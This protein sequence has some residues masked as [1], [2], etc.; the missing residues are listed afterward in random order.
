MPEILSDDG[1][2][3]GCFL[4]SLNLLS[5]PTLRAFRR[6]E[7]YGLP[8]L[9]AAK[10]T[11]LTS[12]EMHEYILPILTA[13]EAIAFGVVKPLHSSLFQLIFLFLFLNSG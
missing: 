11:S 1:H 10:S 5:L 6:I 12:G 13:D 2:S 3:Y 4:D 9:Q 7:L 8:L